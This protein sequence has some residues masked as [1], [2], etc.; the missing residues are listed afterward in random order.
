MVG[1]ARTIRVGQLLGLAIGDDRLQLEAPIGMIPMGGDLDVNGRI[2]TV[3]KIESDCM[4]G[5]DTVH[6]SRVKSLSE[7]I[8]DEQRYQAR[9]P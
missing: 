3:Y 2:Y 8:R 9:R 1:Y 7:M 6:L 4:T 5:L